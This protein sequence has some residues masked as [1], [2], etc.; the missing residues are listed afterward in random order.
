MVNIKQAGIEDMDA[1]I[2]LFIAYRTFYKF[3]SD[4]EALRDYLYERL[5]NNQCVIFL[6]VINDTG[7]TETAIGF[8]QLYPS[9]S[10]LSLKKTWTLFDLFV[11]PEARQLS[12]GQQLMNRAKQMAHESGACEIMLHTAADNVTAQRLYEKLGYERD[13]DFYSYYLL[14]RR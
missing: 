4:P 8:T 6:A 1:I 9:F 2:P 3:D 12:V 7:A 14:L 10:S 11:S 13:N 5:K